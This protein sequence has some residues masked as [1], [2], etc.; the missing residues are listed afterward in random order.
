MK[1]R[2]RCVKSLPRKV[3]PSGTSDISKARKEARKRLLAAK[4]AGRQCKAWE[5]EEGIQIFIS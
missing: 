4:L 5:T 2:D 3:N 1:P